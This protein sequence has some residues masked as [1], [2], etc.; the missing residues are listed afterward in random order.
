MD[1]AVARKLIDISVDN[2][3][4]NFKLIGGE[5]T[6]YPYFFQVLEYLINIKANI[7]IV[8]NGI[9]LAD[10]EF[11][12]SLKKYNYSKLRIGISIKGASEEDYIQDCG[13]RGYTFFLE[14]VKN[15]EDVGLNYSLS[16]V[17]TQDN[18]QNLNQFAKNLKSSGINKT[19]FMAYCKNMILEENQQSDIQLKMDYDFSQK[20][21][22]LNEIL[23]DRLRIHQTFPLC[24][25]EP[26]T[27]TKL[28]KKRQINTICHVHKRNALIFDTDGSILMCNQL[29]G[30][31][32]GKF[33]VDF[34]DAKSFKEYWNSDYLVELYNRFT[35]MPSNKCQYCELFSKCGG[36]CFIQWFTQNFNEYERYKSRVLG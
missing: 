3:I 7:V 31:G 28:L 1:I 20:Y 6:I 13:A 16:Y 22:M 4:N 24:L 30:Y 11:C 19:I 29:A 15:C 12:N 21:E 23:E 35:T 34:H 26:T 18:I 27:L 10:K 33:G 2:G 9:R 8:S 25:C 17:L 32:I 5:P 14:A 36:G